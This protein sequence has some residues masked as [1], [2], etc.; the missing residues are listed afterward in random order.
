MD[1]VA[2]LAGKRWKV[3]MMTCDVTNVPSEVYCCCGGCWTPFM[4]DAG[5]AVDRGGKEETAAP[6]SYCRRN[7]Q[8]G[9]GQ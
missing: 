4:A 5:E 3:S 7:K 1:E 8:R 6:A 9:V 2:G